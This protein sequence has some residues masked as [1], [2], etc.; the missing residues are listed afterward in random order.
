MQKIAV[1]ETPWRSAGQWLRL[2]DMRGTSKMQ[3][4]DLAEWAKAVGRSTAWEVIPA[5]QPAPCFPKKGRKWAVD[6]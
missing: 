3:R 5:V 1:L 4:V 6:L 2:T